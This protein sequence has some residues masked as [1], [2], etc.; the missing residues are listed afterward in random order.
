[1]TDF[2]VTNVAWDD[3]DVTATNGTVGTA[4]VAAQ[5][6]VIT[7]TGPLED[8]VIIY[9]NTY[10]GAIVPLVKA[11]AGAASLRASAT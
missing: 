9:T 4:I 11:G 2:A 7:P 3:N 6:A 10:A 5:Y 1:M 8:M